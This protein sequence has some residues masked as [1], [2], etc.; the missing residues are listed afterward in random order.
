LG[1][2]RRK[3][4]RVQLNRLLEV[5]GQVKVKDLFLLPSRHASWAALLAPLIWELLRPVHPF[6]KA[7]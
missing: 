1:W 5:K 2:T 3:G 6:E 4:R 7:S